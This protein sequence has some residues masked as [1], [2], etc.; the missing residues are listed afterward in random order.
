MKD[1]SVWASQGGR[2]ISIGPK[3]LGAGPQREGGGAALITCSGVQP[4]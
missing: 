2:F 1:W 3:E 4:Q